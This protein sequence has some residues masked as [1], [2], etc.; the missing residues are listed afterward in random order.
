MLHNQSVVGLVCQ[1]TFEVMI[2][3]NARRQH[4]TEHSSQFDEILGL[5]RVDKIEYKI[6]DKI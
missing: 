5:A 2:E 3:C 1:N 6:E 4:T